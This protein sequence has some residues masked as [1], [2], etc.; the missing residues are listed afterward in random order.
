M[1][2]PI[3]VRVLGDLSRFT[4]GNS[5]EIEGSGWSPGAVLQE[6]IRRYPGLGREVFDEQGRIHYALVLMADGKPVA[7]P[8][9]KDRPIEDGGE[10]LMT[11]FHSGG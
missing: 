3:T 6:L 5:L 10:L 1:S 11:R 4:G 8:N 7:W 2:M 9:D